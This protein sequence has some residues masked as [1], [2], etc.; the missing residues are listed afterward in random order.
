M[1]AQTTKLLVVAEGFPGLGGERVTKL[2]KYLPQAGIEPLVLTTT[3]KRGAV[4][5]SF[6]DQVAFVVPQVYES[7]Y[8]R[9]S[10]FKVFAKLFGMQSLSSFLD[11]FWFVPDQYITW[12]PSAVIKGL[13]TVKN[14]GI[15][16]ILTTSPPESCHLIGYVLSRLTHRPWISDFRDLWTV[17]KIVNKPATIFHGVIHKRMES[18]VFNSCSHI[19]ANTEG[20]RQIYIKDFGISEQKIT[21]IPNGFDLQDMRRNQSLDSGTR[22]SKFTIGYLGYFDKP[23]FPWREFLLILKE[24]SRSIGD[25]SVRL[26]ICGQVSQAAMEFIEENGLQNIVRSNGVLSHHDAVQIVKDCSILLLLLY[27]TGYSR[28]IVPHK[29]Y[30]YLGMNRPVVA[31]AEEDGEVASILKKTGSGNCFS[32]NN[33]EGFLQGLLNYYSQWKSNRSIEYHGNTETIREYEWGKL[34]KRLAKV[35]LK[36]MSE[37]KNEKGLC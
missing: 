30:N 32:V 14:K 22:R 7:F 4:G 16:A 3:V 10:P 12:V 37:N 36:V 15:D 27:E 19:I 23:G 34:S 17:K 35:V 33:R 31:M 5:I 9:K 18:F 20:N 29:L 25:D 24:L 6:P 11:R 2:V 1:S 26:I 8:L 13:Q 28:S 21:L